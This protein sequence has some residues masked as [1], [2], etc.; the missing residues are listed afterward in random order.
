[1]ACD[2]AELKIMDLGMMDYE[3]CLEIQNNLVRERIAD[4]SSDCLLLVTHPPVITIGKSGDRSDAFLS[5]GELN[6]KG[7]QLCRADRGGKTTYH[8]PGQLVVYPIMKLENKDVHWYVQALLNV[9]SSV[10]IDYDLKPELRPG[11][12]GVWVNDGKIASIGISVK[13]WVA[14]HGVALNIHTDLSCFELINPCGVAGQ[15]ITSMNNETVTPQDYNRVA[16]SFITHFKKAFG[17]SG[18]EVQRHPEWLR[19]P[20]HNH[21][22]TENVI[23]L[24]RSLNLE[25]VCQSA[26]CPNLGE[27][28][29][30]GTAT[31]MI[32]G[33]YCTRNCRFCAVEHGI[34][35]PLDR[36][37]PFRVARAVKKMALQYV[38][39]TSVTRDD[40]QDGGAE[41][42]VRT[43]S[44]IRK[45]CPG[46][47][48]EVLVP[49]FMGNTEAVEAVCHAAPDMFNHNVETVSRL[50]ALVRPQAR[51]HRSLDVLNQASRGGLP[52]KSGLMLGLGESK[53]EVLDTLRDL[54]RAGCTHVTIG[55]YLPPSKNHIPLSCYIHPDEFEEWSGI[56]QSLGFKGVVSGSLSRS[57][58]NADLLF[59]GR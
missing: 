44:E 42:F 11:L 58:Y 35:L 29:S 53:D 1:M 8:G 43:I 33:G 40:L 7:I 13:K 22:K 14:Y 48:V 47:R 21:V 18:R 31:F 50:S 4:T 28:F 52:V 9:I 6:A 19:I 5:D 37:E 30:K 23:E 57:S 25:T 34:P 49:D 10:L 38:V 15:L 17:Y 46:T 3:E 20:T 56:A 27:C 54:L 36:E 51:Y 39:I 41:Q 26:H 12:P 59:N 16:A 32:L 2:T 24:V 45:T 55:Q